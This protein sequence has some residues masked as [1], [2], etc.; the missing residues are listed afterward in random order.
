MYMAKHG[1]QKLEGIQ[2]RDKNEQMN[3]L[4]SWVG[5]INIVK[6]PV[7]I[8]ILHAVPIKVLITE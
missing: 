3:L 8:Y 2:K 6:M 4:T 1:W 7:A 5:R